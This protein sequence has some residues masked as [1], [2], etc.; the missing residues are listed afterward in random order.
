MT[1]ASDSLAIARRY[2]ALGFSVIPVP[3]P[4]PGVP[5]GQP[6]D[7]KV[8]ILAWK[9]F[10]SRRPTD[11]ELAFWFSGEPMNLAVV[12]GAISGVV[13]VDADDEP[14]RLWCVRHLPYTPWQTRTNGGC[15]LWFRHPGVLVSNRARLE[16][17]DGRLKIDLRADG[18]YVVAPGSVH[19]SGVIYR[20]AGDWTRP[21]ADLP[22]FWRGWLQRPNRP[23]R[24]PKPTIR[25]T[26]EVV[27]RARRYLAAIPLPVIGA[28]SDAATFSA[29]CRLVRGF[30][31]DAATVEQ[32]LWEWA[33]NRDGWTRQWIARKVASAER[34]GREPVGGLR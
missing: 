22:C 19:A 31:L 27:E 21:I 1:P 34:S 7:G 32:L 28:G 2:L 8:P 10:Q 20:E 4:R 13:V 26:G 11:E 17:S 23:S 30:D 24:E 5:K 16:T 29:A 18:G 14:A 9:E 12:T 3:R 6:G 15:H 25:P 33:G